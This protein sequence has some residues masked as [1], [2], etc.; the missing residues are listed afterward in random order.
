MTDKGTILCHTTVQHRKI[1]VTK[2]PNISDKVKD[3]TYTLDGNL[4]NLK[5]IPTKSD[6]EGFIM[7][8]YLPN[9]RYELPTNK[10]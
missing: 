6:F 9:Q 7:D 4:S 8:Y 1:D 3:Y 5:Y 2:Y 10:W